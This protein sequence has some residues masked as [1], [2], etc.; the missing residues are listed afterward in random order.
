MESQSLIENILLSKPIT[1]Y[2]EQKGIVP[3]K[4]MSGRL[5]Y[6]CPFPDHKETKPSFVVYT[7]GEFENFYCFGCNRKYHIIDLV[8]KLEKIS[9]KESVSRLSDGA[10][11]TPFDE[12]QF[13][14]RKIRDA[15]I[16]PIDAFGISETLMMMSSSCRMYEESV[17]RDKDEL[18]KMDK[19]WG[20]V[21]GCVLDSD[22][23]AIKE[24]EP[25]LRVGLKTFRAR[26]ER[27]RKEKIREDA[28]N[29]FFA[30]R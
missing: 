30:K 4:R 7:T 29:E 10:V 17:G 21:D 22:F 9:F 8:S 2:L 5:W 6:Q 15:F 18:E 1:A 11:I 3:V 19:F 13:Q 27:E 14:G 28:K 24:F 20:V 16:H 25:H 12:T 23:D 26:F